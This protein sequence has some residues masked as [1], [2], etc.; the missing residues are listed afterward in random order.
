MLKNLKGKK[1]LVTG[2]PKRI[3]RAITLAL[4]REGVDIAVHYLDQMEEAEALCEEVRALKVN[5]W[6]V[7]ADFTR[8]EEYETLI[9]R[10]ISQTG[11]LDILINNASA[12]S[13]DHLE[14]MNFTGLMRKIEINAWVPLVLSR[15]FGRGREG[16]I[17]NIL[18]TK[19][20]AQDLEHASYILSKKM[21]A[22]L[23]EMMALEFGPGIT[24]NAIAPG[25]ILPPAG[26][27]ETY[28]ARL[29]QDIP[30]QR[31]GNPEYIASAVI[32]LLTNDFMTGQV[33]F[34]DGGRH[35]KGEA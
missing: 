19:I 20:T 14:D 16:N 18:D 5:A 2:A 15:E 7:Q 9:S 33:L 22:T 27:D 29:A 6:A 10:T 31:S 12:F 30:L 26:K 17:I 8:P 35:L 1:A 13:A 21:L 23:T 25:L 34:V 4:A 11:S 24:V 28:L 32:Y 3:G